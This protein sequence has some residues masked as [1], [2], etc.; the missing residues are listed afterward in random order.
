MKRLLPY[1]LFLSCMILCSIAAKATHVVGAD[2]YY[3]WITGNQYKITVIVYGDCGPASAGSFALLPTASPQVCVFDGTSSVTSLSLTIQAP[4]A[5]TEIT[6]VCP[7]DSLNTQCHSTSSPTPGIKKFVYTKTYTLPYASANW[8]FVFTGNLGAGSSAGRAAALTNLPVTPA[9][10]MCLVATLNNSTTYNSNPILTILPVPFFCLNGD[11]NYNPGAVDAD[12]DSLSFALT[13]ASNYTGGTTCNTSSISPCAYVTTYPYSGSNPLHTLPGTFGFDPVTGQISFV[14]DILQRSVVVYTISEWRNGVLMG[15][16][17]REM[18]FTVLTCT[19]PAP[20]GYLLAGGATNGT[21]DDSTHFHICANNGPFAISMGASS[22]NPL[23]NITVSNT[24]VP[25][26]CT[27]NVVN[28]GTP[29]PN[30]TVS[31]T[32]TGVTPGSYT[33]FLNFR[34]NACPINGQQ[35]KAFTI[36]IY[37]VPSVTY[38]IVDTNTCSH[39]SIVSIS[40]SGAGTPWV[41]RYV[42]SATGISFDSSTGVTAAYLDT[43]NTGFDTLVIYNAASPFCNSKVTMNI[44]PPVF[45]NPTGIHTDPTFCGANDGSITLQGLKSLEADTLFYTYNGIPVPT[46]IPIFTSSAGTYVIPNLCAGT[47]TN[48]YVK[49]G[50]CTSPPLGPITLIAPPFTIGRLETTNPTACGLNDGSIKILGVHPGQLDTVR[51][52]RNGVL[53]PPYY[54]FVGADSTI[55]LNNLDSA[56]Y[57]N[58]VVNTTGACPNATGCTSNILGPAILQDVRLQAGFT[59]EVHMGC[60]GDTLF[61]NNTSIPS[62]STVPLTY[63]WY[64]GDGGTDTSKNPMHVYHH[65]TAMTY[66][67]KMFFS[68]GHCIDSAVN[69][70]NL[71]APVHADFVSNAG[72]YICQGSAVDFRDTSS[73]T[74]LTWNWSFGD[75]GVATDKDPSHTYFNTGTYVVTLIST[76]NIPCK[77]TMTKV[78]QVDST[79]VVSMRASD[80]VI[81]R[82]GLVTFTG[83]YTDI[84]L[85][86]VSWSFGDGT[87]YNNANPVQHSFDATGWLPVTMTV[88]YRACATVVTT[89][90]IKVYDNPTLYLG[91]DTSICPGSDAI[92]L[93]DLMNAGNPL[94]SWMWSTGETTPN[95]VVDKP[96]YYSA[97]VTI[98]GCINTDTVWVANDCYVSFPNIFTPNGDGVNDYFFPRSILSSGLIAFKMDIYNRW[99]QNVYSTTSTDGQGWDGRFNGEMQ[100]QGVFIYQI[101]AVFKDGQKL[102]KK[103]NVTLL[104]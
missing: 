19:T 92:E 6:P 76:D 31:W 98:N 59:Y 57:T 4:S 32:S 48:I 47:Y 61:F 1:F 58:I 67:I 39:P 38:T 44:I 70:V 7:A 104:R 29:N 71:Q 95:I 69:T 74:G 18:S 86:G 101:D 102:S 30:I 23:L 42:N 88:T 16:M 33:F 17:Q 90:N 35:T 89:R 56:V 37:P 26:G 82:G 84:G 99:G 12:G 63:R 50:L 55:I 51:F 36:S 41:V 46:G 3:T 11:D 94:A 78:V 81:C 83:T 20:D 25:P 66:T 79:S 62:T 49:Y 68:N 52:T 65:A 73:G 53:Q 15:T 40:P 34:D 10:T 93:Y 24:G 64:F 9:T 77:D 60:D 75:G 100:P 28:N 43:F 8:K 14:P 13:P 45:V 97:T 91:P 27:V 72:S 87:G 5:G 54:I 103:G 85:T 22:T 96:G 80:T 21:V 2:L